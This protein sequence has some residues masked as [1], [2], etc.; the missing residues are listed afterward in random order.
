MSRR[1]ARGWRGAGGIAAIAMTPLFQACSADSCFAR[2]TRV[3][4]PRGPR[5]IEDL[6]IG[7][8][9]WSWD[10]EKAQAIERPVAR[11]IRSERTE[12]LALRAGELRVAGVTPD[13]PFYDADAR[14]FRQSIELSLGTRLLAW[15]GSGDPRTVRVDAIERLPVHAPVTVWDLTIDG[16]EHDFFADGLLVHN[17]RGPIAP[18]DAAV[19]VAS[20]DAGRDAASSDDG[21]PQSGSSGDAS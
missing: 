14:R 11:V 15:L 1:I 13:H 20:D 18:Q 8:T 19:D 3:A 16:P 7:D 5:A 21:G 4:T 9:V 10:V 12:L 17:K 6:E 2:G